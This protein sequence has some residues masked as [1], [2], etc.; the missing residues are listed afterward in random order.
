[1]TVKIRQ[2]LQG[3][4]LTGAFL[5]AVAARA[6]ITTVNPGYEE[7]RWVMF[8]PNDS[9]WS[10]ALGK[11]AD[12]TEIKCD[13]PTISFARLDALLDAGGSREGFNRHVDTGKL[14][15]T[16]Y[17][18]DASGD[19][20]YDN[21]GG[22]D[23]GYPID[24]RY[25]R[26]KCAY[27]K[28]QGKVSVP[29][30]GK[31][32]VCIAASD[33]TLLYLKLAKAG[34]TAFEEEIKPGWYN[35][36]LLRVME[37]E[38]GEYDL[39][40]KQF[41]DNEKLY[42]EISSAEGEQ[43]SFNKSTFALISAPI[44]E[45]TVT[46]DS[47]GG[48]AVPEQK[49]VGGRVLSAP[50]DPVREGAAFQ[51]WTTDPTVASPQPYDFSQPVTA[52]LTL[53]AIWVVNQKPVIQS[54]VSTPSAAEISG[55]SVD[56]ALSVV[57]TDADPADVLSYLWTL[58]GTAPSSYA[59]D[60]A[61]VASPT[62]TVMGPGSYT[63]K[64]V[65]SDGHES[66]SGTVTVVVT[67]AEGATSFSYVGADC[68]ADHKYMAERDFNPDLD[69]YPWPD[70]KAAWRSTGTV[71]KAFLLDD[72]RPNAYGLDGYVFP[73][74]SEYVNGSKVEN[75]TSGT[76]TYD[77]TAKTMVYGETTDY[78]TSIELKGPVTRGYI[79]GT[80]L[81][82]L[83]SDGCVYCIDD[84]AQPLGENVTDFRPGAL[85]IHVPNEDTFVPFATITFN[86][87]V[88]K[89]PKVRIGFLSGYSLKFK[90]EYVSVGSA[91]AAWPGNRTQNN[92]MPDWVF[93]DIDNAKAGDR[94][95]LSVKN[96]N[97]N[98]WNSTR[99]EGIVFDSVEKNPGLVVVFR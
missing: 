55:T 65:V 22:V 53:T 42:Y 30:T 11:W 83:G 16:G 2:V 33:M 43:A 4:V 44:V 20:N 7:W 57:A 32:T 50:A 34:A 40:F 56:L 28:I 19:F 74:N 96:Y 70:T 39:T 12:G 93:F 63:F 59:F 76:A 8:N 82:E 98:Q 60:D 67:L 3:M 26:W 49:I 75:V 29:T 80:T 9:E 77:E 38:A 51:F 84:P 18:L 92:C 85:A 90:P 46:F 72:E 87:K 86:R 5:A 6:G 24:N 71:R 81:T 64:V 13:D 68:T 91:V 66:D 1:M 94:V 89:H 78:I 10:S 31:W 52:D 21:N 36:H 45:Y 25:D 23:G 58:E 88:R 14:T 47:A 95:V 17:T 15:L 97:N 99:I 41:S 69:K 48:T 27:F 37:L 35:G 61:T 73:G 62:V 79:Q 54:L